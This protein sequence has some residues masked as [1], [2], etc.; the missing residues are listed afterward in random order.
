MSH[1]SINSLYERYLHLTRKLPKKVRWLALIIAPAG[2]TL[3]VLLSGLLGVAGALAI[4]I[5]LKHITIENASSTG[6]AWVLIAA[7]ISEGLSRWTKERH[8]LLLTSVIRQI[9]YRRF[10]RLL[11][12]RSIPSRA[13]KNIY[14][15]P[16][17]IS[18]F[19]FMVDGVVSTIQ[20]VSF[21]ILSLHYYGVSGAIAAILIA[22]IALASIKLV[23]RIGELWENYISGEGDRRRWLQRTAEALPRGSRLPSWG[24]ATGKLAQ[25][26]KAQEHLLYRRV[27]LQVFNGFLDRGGG[28]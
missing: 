8:E 7:F 20:V 6:F 5:S 12:D 9:T 13:R 3:T 26:R 14:T 10:R 15:F 17:Q 11:S 18:Q 23:H 21:I 25:I 16:G 27:P 4:T 28:H 2:I 1:I 22:G 19:A 24:F